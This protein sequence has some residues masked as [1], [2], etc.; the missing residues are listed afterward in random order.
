MSVKVFRGDT[1]TRAWRLTDGAGNPLDLAGCT[2]RLHLRDAAGEKAAEAS[3]ADGRIAIDGQAGRIAM[4]MPAAA[5]NLAPGA[6]RFD[7]E[8]TGAG[9]AVTTLEQTT[10]VVLEDCTHD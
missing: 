6:Y 4:T 2:A 9:G 10:L 7:L 8:L 3:T 1:W 5:M